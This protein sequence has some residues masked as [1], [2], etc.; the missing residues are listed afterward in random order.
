MDDLVE[1]L[2][3][4]YSSP[5]VL[6]YRAPTLNPARF[7]ISIQGVEPNLTHH[8]LSLLSATLDRY[9]WRT[10]T[11]SVVAA[12]DGSSYASLV[13]DLEPSPGQE[14]FLRLLVQSPRGFSLAVYG[15]GDVIVEDGRAGAVKLWKERF[16]LICKD[17]EATYAAQHA[18]TYAVLSKS[19]F[20]VNEPTL[21][22]ASL[23]LFDP[24][25]AP[26][27]FFHI[28]N[29]DGEPQP[30]GQASLPPQPGPLM[31]PSDSSHGLLH[32]SARL[33]TP[34]EDGYTVV[35]SCLCPRVLRSGRLRVR[36]LSSLAL[37]M[38]QPEACTTVAEFSDQYTPNFRRII[39]REV[40]SSQ[41]ATQLAVQ[42]QAGSAEVPIVCRVVDE[43]AGLL[44]AQQTSFHF[45]LFPVL[46]LKKNKKLLV[47][48]SL[49]PV[50][51][52]PF[53]SSRFT[54]KLRVI[55]GQGLNVGRD[56]TQEQEFASIKAGWERAH[57]GRSQKARLA[58]EKYLSTHPV[59]VEALPSSHD[60]KELDLAELG[61]GRRV[62]LVGDRSQAR[63]L[64]PQ[65]A[66]QR[67]AN[68]VKQDATSRQQKETLNVGRERDIEAWSKWLA[69]HTEHVQ[70][71]RQELLS[72]KGQ[73]ATA[74]Q[75]YREHFA[76]FEESVFALRVATLAN[77]PAEAAIRQALSQL[78]QVATEKNISERRYAPIVE[79]A[80]QILKRIAAPAAP[81]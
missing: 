3:C 40:I 22:S 44:L 10:H 23:L 13:V 54:W 31:P 48:C 42:C 78:N 37:P 69:E 75:A 67:K 38:L 74:R 14:Q 25:L 80:E 1:D 5:H 39:C 34:N 70:G 45:C 36:L 33:F 81:T 68:R 50:L 17:I 64:T 59:G 11:S 24:D 63:P 2:T 58:R 9:W 30:L 71:W 35:V 32:V 79:I 4:A 26:F 51:G 61:P 77:P 19:V 56:T 28:I 66:A 76:A 12:V 43:E 73:E 29:N 21:V 47:E 55:S 72:R 65:L 6:F 60:F 18:N 62:R 15:Q 41:N 57:P 46:L 8:G 49:D 53:A 16:G 27:V 7:I 52:V 20:R